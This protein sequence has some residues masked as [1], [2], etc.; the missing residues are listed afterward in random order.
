MFTC[1]SLIIKRM[2]TLK[3]PDVLSTCR[4]VY[5]AVYACRDII[6]RRNNLGLFHELFDTE[7]DVA[8]P[9][10]SCSALWNSKRT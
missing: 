3:N 10:E 5:S 8:Y 1:D 9:S 4:W 7:R 2:F 6:K